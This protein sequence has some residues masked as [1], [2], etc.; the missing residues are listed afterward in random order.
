MCLCDFQIVVCRAADVG[1]GVAGDESQPDAAAEPADGQRHR[2]VPAAVG[3][4]V[5]AGGR[6]AVRAG[7]FPQRSLSGN[8]TTPAN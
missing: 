7:V 8:Q 4:D 2:V 3:Q 1:G 6:E 5:P